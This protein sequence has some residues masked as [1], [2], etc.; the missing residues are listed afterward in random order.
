MK[1]L[2]CLPLLSLVACT[3][4][5]SD[6]AHTAVSQYLKT[7]ANDPASYEAVRWSGAAGYTRR[8]SAAAAAEKLFN[9]YKDTQS[10]GRPSGELSIIKESLRLSKVTDTTR[11]GTLLTHAYRGKNKLGAIVLDSAQFV[12]YTNGQVQA[13]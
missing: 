5:D 7:H 12:V 6:P 10:E 13:L 3:A 2:L 8:D 9:K 11:V 4:T 1:K